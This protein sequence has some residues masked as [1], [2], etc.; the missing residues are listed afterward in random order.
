MILTGREKEALDELSAMAERHETAAEAYE[1]LLLDEA[2]RIF[3]T[4]A[5]ALDGEGRARAFREL[6]AEL[7]I[8]RR[9][10]AAKVFSERLR[11]EKDCASPFPPKP[12]GERFA[13][14]ES[15][16]SAALKERLSGGRLVRAESFEE[17]CE[18]AGD[19]RA[20]GCILPLYDAQGRLLSG[21]RRMC[22]D[23]GLKK[24]R[25]FAL[26]HG[27]E[28]AVYALFSENCRDEEDADCLEYSFC[29]S[30]DCARAD[31]TALFEA[32]GL[33]CRTEDDGR[34]CI[35]SAFGS[36]RTLWA[37]LEGARLFCPDGAVEGFFRSG[38]EQ[39]ENNG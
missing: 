35:L 14:C 3:F 9:W 1:A 11:G 10:L 19:G 36:K 4:R 18:M 29:P 31:M 26:E 23:L 28:R 7:S 25:L 13:V 22:A 33:A 27:E 20:D 2:A 39:E 37:S 32:Y 21:V 6:T 38:G 5:G 17:A 8:K 34:R 15:R 24:R 30:K 16:F 12:E